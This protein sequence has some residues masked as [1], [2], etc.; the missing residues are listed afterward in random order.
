MCMYEEWVCISYKY[1]RLSRL[2]WCCAFHFKERRNSLHWKCQW[3]LNSK[4]KKLQ[5]VCMFHFI[6]NIFGSFSLSHYLLLSRTKSLKFDRYTIIGIVVS[7]ATA[8]YCNPIPELWISKKLPNKRQQFDFRWVKKA[9]PLQTQ[10]L[11]L[12][13]IQLFGLWCIKFGE[14]LVV[15]VT[16]CQL[17]MCIAHC[18]CTNAR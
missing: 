8:H 5:F 11:L 14:L 12:V 18:A 16:C 6:L 17:H 3:T 7:V 4:L 15:F 9:V 2:F 13:Q 1:L 10:H